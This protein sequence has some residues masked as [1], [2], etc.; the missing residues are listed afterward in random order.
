M[1]CFLFSLLF[2]CVLLVS[3]ASWFASFPC[4]FLHIYRYIF[5]NGDSVIIIVRI[6]SLT[7]ARSQ[8]C[9]K[10]DVVISQNPTDRSFGSWTRG[11][12]LVEVIG[13]QLVRLPKTHRQTMAI[14]VTPRGQ[15]KETE[16]NRHFQAKL[17]NNG[18]E[19][20][21]RLSSMGAGSFEFL[22]N[23]P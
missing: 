17:D 13:L 4:I 11:V 22:L 23:S 20:G 7:I 12:W 19:V 1:R 9:V 14:F 21:S 2:I 10:P 3:V 6:F 16:G 15:T 5:L 18:N 8:K